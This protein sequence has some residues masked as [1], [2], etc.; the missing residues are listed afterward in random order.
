VSDLLR[1]LSTLPCRH[2]LAIFDTCH[3]G[4]ALGGT[5]QA[6]RDAVRYEQDLRSRVS[7]KV[8]TSARHDQRAL[9]GGPIPPPWSSTSA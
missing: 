1:E 6:F 4:I 3:S 7:R 5:V 2:V 9:D 8:I